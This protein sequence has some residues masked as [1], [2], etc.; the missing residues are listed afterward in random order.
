MDN[1]KY[2]ANRGYQNII[3]KISDSDYELIISNNIIVNIKRGSNS[4]FTLSMENSDFD[5]YCGVLLKS[6]MWYT[7]VKVEFQ[8]VQER[9]GCVRPNISLGGKGYFDIY[10]MYYYSQYHNNNILDDAIEGQY[11][12]DGLLSICKKKVF[13]IEILYSGALIGQME[14]IPLVTFKNAFFDTRS[15]PSPTINMEPMVVRYNFNY[16]DYDDYFSEYVVY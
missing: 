11:T 12:Q 6:F 1:Y 3:N 14:P 8:D 15:V 7:P 5:D 10:Y 2:Y 16:T 4:I 9:P 13:D